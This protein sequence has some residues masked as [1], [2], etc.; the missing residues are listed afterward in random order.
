MFIAIDLLQFKKLFVSKL[1]DMLS[2][3]ELGAFIL[4]LAN[5]RQDTF[6]KNELQA[7]LQKTLDRK[8][9]V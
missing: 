7:D 1:K 8:S 6:L 4:V 3:D 2:D 9:V 5:S